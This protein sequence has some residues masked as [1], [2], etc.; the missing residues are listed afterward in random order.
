MYVIVSLALSS[1]AKERM[2]SRTSNGRV[3]IDGAVVEVVLVEAM[4][5]GE[6]TGFTAADKTR[7]IRR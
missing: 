4:L 6:I 3:F 2:R 1:A 5:G 7:G